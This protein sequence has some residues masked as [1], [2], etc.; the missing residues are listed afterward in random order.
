M[1]PERK[2]CFAF[3]AKLFWNLKNFIVEFSLINYCKSI[4]WEWFFRKYFSKRTSTAPFRWTF[5]WMQ[6]LNHRLLKQRVYL[7]FIKENP[8]TEWTNV[9]ICVWISLKSIR[10]FA[11]VCSN[12]FAALDNK[13]GVSL[14]AIKCDWEPLINKTRF[15]NIFDEF[16]HASITRN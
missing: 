12:S 11:F 6:N 14:D 9:P 5:V 2:P 1:R 15:S 10:A 4:L 8:E 16:K 13:K 3:M 7:L